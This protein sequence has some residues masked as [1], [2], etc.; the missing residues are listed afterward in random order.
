ML[1]IGPL[2]AGR[3]STLTDFDYRECARKAVDGFLSVHRK[4]QGV[5][6]TSARPES[7]GV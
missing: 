1:L 6:V 4:P 2:V 5:Q 3:I 7:A